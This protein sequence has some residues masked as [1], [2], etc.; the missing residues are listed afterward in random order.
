MARVSRKKLKIDMGNKVQN[1]KVVRDNSKIPTAVYCRLSKA[2]EV[3]GKESMVS[4][5]LSQDHPDFP[6]TA[7]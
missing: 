7:L 3:T 1:E 6:H 4:Q 5:L 2:D